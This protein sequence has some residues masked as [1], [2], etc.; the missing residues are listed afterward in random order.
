MKHLMSGFPVQTH[1]DLVEGEGNTYYSPMA[2]R[3]HQQSRIH[4]RKL[5]EHAYMLLVLQTCSQ[6]GLPAIV[7]SM[8]RGNPRGPLEGIMT[9]VT[10]FTVTGSLPGT[11]HTWQQLVYAK[12]TIPIAVDELEIPI[13]STTIDRDKAHVSHS[14]FPSI[15]RHE[16]G[17]ELLVELMYLVYGN[18][19]LQEHA[20]VTHIT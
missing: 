6:L 5:D 2:C 16:G 13:I 7:R 8:T 15:L 4:D 11:W 19:Y 3:L 12:A 18:S 10:E 1:G 17:A 9:A 20:P 14:F